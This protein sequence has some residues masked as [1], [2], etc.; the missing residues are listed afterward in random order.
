[1]VDRNLFDFGKQDDWYYIE[2]GNYVDSIHAAVYLPF[3]ER[4]LY[5]VATLFDEFLK[6]RF[7]VRFVKKNELSEHLLWEALND[8]QLLYDN[9]DEIFGKNP[10]QEDS[11]CKWT[12][13]MLKEGASGSN[14]KVIM[15]YLVQYCTRVCVCSEQ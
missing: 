14:T 2:E 4:C 5:A 10:D 15:F 3:C 8:N 6:D 7:I 13:S 9:M 12:T 1:M 11:Y